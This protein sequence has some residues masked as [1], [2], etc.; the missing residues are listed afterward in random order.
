VRVVG[1]YSKS[2][3][4]YEDEISMVVVL[5][6]SSPTYLARERSRSEKVDRV[7]PINRR[8]EL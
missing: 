7:T 4:S 5:R 1:G 2:R 6:R 8:R 3:Q